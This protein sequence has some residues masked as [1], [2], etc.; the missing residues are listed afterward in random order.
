MLCLLL[1]MYIKG[2]LIPCPLSH[3]SLSS[4]HHLLLLLVVVMVVIAV[5]NMYNYVIIIG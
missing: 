1:C 3:P 2:I 4:L 5:V